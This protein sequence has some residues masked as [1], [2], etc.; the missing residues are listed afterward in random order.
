MRP[1]HVLAGAIFVGAITLVPDLTVAQRYYGGGNVIDN[2]ASTPA[3]SYARGMADVIRSSGAANLMNSRAA[4]NYEDARSKNLDNRVKYAETYYEKRRVHDKYQAEKAEKTR[5]YFYRRSQKGPSIAR[6]T[7]AELD[8]VTGKI[9]WP[10]VLQDKPFDAYRKQLDS[11]FAR[12]ETSLGAIG[13]QSY[14]EL[15]KTI[16]EMQRALIKRIREY[17]S[18]EYIKAREYLKRLAYEASQAV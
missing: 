2:R 14:V 7:P 4:S 11:A 15:L 13:T 5:E 8:P 12:R 16:E 17:P 6:L 9:S 3:E 1:L 10:L 18:S